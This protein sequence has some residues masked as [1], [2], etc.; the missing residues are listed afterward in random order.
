MTDPYLT[1]TGVLKN[2]LSI[3]DSRE[4][5]DAEADFSQLRLFDLQ[6]HKGPTG[7]FDSNYLH[8]LHHYIFQDVYPWAGRTRGDGIEINGQVIEALP[9]FAKEQTMFTLSPR[10]NQQ[11]D[12]LLEQIDKTGFASMTRSE[13]TRQAAFILGRLNAIH[14]FREG[15]GRTQRAFVDALAHLAGHVLAWDVISRERMISVS[16]DSAQGQPEPMERL[17]EEIA[18]SSLVLELRGAIGFLEAQKINWNER[19]VAMAR[20]EMMI[21]GIVAARGKRYAIVQTSEGHVIVTPFDQIR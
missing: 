7:Q 6:Q 13:F 12:D 10:V 4:L 16:V 5:Q 19:Y 14:P 2:L 8:A 11:L 18:D 9:L 1:K 20:P 17:L 15:N 3:G 21:E